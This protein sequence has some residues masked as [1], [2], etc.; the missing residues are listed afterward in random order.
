[1]RNL[2]HKILVL[3]I[4]SFS[5]SV[6]AQ[7]NKVID[8][9]INNKVTETV[10]SGKE[11][12]VSIINGLPNGTPY[13]II[14]KIEFEEIGILEFPTEDSGALGLDGGSP[15]CD[16]IQD[17]I[18][19]I[20]AIE[21]ES[22]IPE[23]YSLFKKK[24]ELIKA[25]F[26][27]GDR[28]KDEVKKCTAQHILYATT[29]VEK[30]E[31]KINPLYYKLKKGEKLTITISRKTED[32]KVKE[33][34]YVYKTQKRG[35]WFTSYGLGFAHDNIN[36]KET[37]YLTPIDETYAITRKAR[38]TIL[39]YI[40]TIFFSWMP[41]NDLSENFSW[42]FTGGIGYDLEAP[43]GFLGGSVFFNQRLGLSAGFAFHKQ[44]V[45]SGQYKEG[46]ILNDLVSEDQLHE[47]NYTV[48]PFISLNYVI[49]KNIF[50]SKQTEVTEGG[51]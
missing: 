37:Y 18:N 39:E 16:I 33:W 3:I 44:D 40:P 26:S 49:N 38:R 8:L 36:K 14:S 28:A 15:I 13:E 20:V 43:T 1:M 41:T 2:I 48:N 32:D 45:L 50:K 30:L 12:I 17:E 22:E 25:E 11:I 10:P 24:L 51:E 47:S 19:T 21:D 42:S 9:S 6:T 31:K 46:Q 29:F 35:K 7:V 23:K 34:T 5:I 4:V 27:K